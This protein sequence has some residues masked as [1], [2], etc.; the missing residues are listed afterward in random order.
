MSFSV[1]P[2][3]TLC[4]CLAASVG[5]NA[6]ASPG[7]SSNKLE[8]LIVSDTGLFA[9]NADTLTLR[10]QQLFDQQTLNPIIDGERVYVTGSRGL[11]AID[12]GSGDVI[13]HYS[14]ARGGFPP[15]LHNQQIYF[16]NRDGVLQVFNASDGA[17]LWERRF[18]G[19][20]YPPAFY[21]DLLFTGGSEGF[22][23]GVDLRNG[24]IRWTYSVG[25]ELVYSPVALV[26]GQIV[27]TTFN[28]EVFS[29]D[30]HG[31]L[32]WKHT[33]E[34]ILSDPLASGEL[35]IF[36]GLDHRLYA[37]DAEDGGKRW[38]RQ[39]PERQATRLSQ[40][41]GS[42]LVSMET[43]RIWEIDALSGELQ[44]EY[45]LPGEPVASPQRFGNQILGFVRTFDGPKAVFLRPLDPSK[46]F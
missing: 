6:A 10:W 22:L 3:L 40:R 18:P 1:A 7:A 24:A 29:I 14:S 4:L 27:A 25:Q 35:L 16:A 28:R 26:N 23:W 30:P 34:A 39:L 13:W 43:G 19:W 31:E 32:I 44:Q 38:Q 12:V 11:Y 17:L 20:I 2:F 46:L 33:Y 5:A 15:V 45:Q 42:I 41:H 36:T 21:G 8:P 37:L 9:F